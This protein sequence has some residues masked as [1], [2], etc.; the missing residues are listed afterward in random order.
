MG[1]EAFDETVLSSEDGK[2]VLFVRGGYSRDE[3]WIGI[4]KVGGSDPDVVVCVDGAD[5]KRA[6]R[7][8]VIGSKRR[9]AKRRPTAGEG[10]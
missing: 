3:V 4:G 9:R 1:E 7:G 5:L 6:L 2:R 8:M 10:E